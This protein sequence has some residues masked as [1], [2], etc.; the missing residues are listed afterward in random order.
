MLDLW[1]P[2]CDYALVYAFV[3]VHVYSVNMWFSMHVC[4]VLP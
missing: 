4:S 3:Y 2:V 1:V